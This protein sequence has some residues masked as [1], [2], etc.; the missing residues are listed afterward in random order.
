MLKG[1]YTLKNIK[2]SAAARDLSFL[3]GGTLLSQII[4]LSSYPIIT[5]LYSP[6]QLGL[7]SI[8]I[9]TLALIGAFANGNYHRAIMIADNLG[10]AV[11]LARLSQHINL[12]L[13]ITVALV[14]LLTYR[15]TPY[16]LFNILLPIS[17]FLF[18]L[19][20]SII[21]LANR[22]RFYKLMAQSRLI[23]STVSII[24]KLTLAIG[25]LPSAFALITGEILG[26]IAAIIF[27]YKTKS[28]QN[29]TAIKI[30]VTSK[31]QFRT[32][33]LRY[34]NFPKFEL[35]SALVFTLSSHLPTFF[36]G[37]QYGHDV[38]GYYAITRLALD[39]PLHLVS[40]AVREVYFQRSAAAY[41]EHGS[42][43]N[44]FHITVAILFTTAATTCLLIQ[45]YWEFLF[46]FVFGSDWSESGRY[47][48]ILSIMYL[49]KFVANPISS[50]FLIAEKQKELLAWQLALL[51]SVL[52]LLAGVYTMNMNIYTCLS[53][54]T[55]IYG[56]FYSGFLIRTWQ[57]SLQ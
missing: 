33:L 36:I 57:L 30:D 37:Y 21:A 14:S 7:F 11:N 38:L 44:I 32:L 23:K 8:F 42:C 34:I 56:L 18:G 31:I 43:R 41:R 5:R 49:F 4:S 39:A 24:L 3:V 35:P 19:N 52:L 55:T 17:L 2:P 6:E 1:N 15:I 12:V 16:P 48:G 25:Y 47:A 28:I 27:L 26:S 54:L 13:V 50:G 45:P 20:E 29:I 40:T 9:S 22:Q 10:S 46:T 53:L 51:C